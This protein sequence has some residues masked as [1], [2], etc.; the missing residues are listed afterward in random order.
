[1]T[2][3]TGFATSSRFER[4]LPRGRHDLAF[5]V[6]F[7]GDGAAARYFGVSR[8]SIWRWRRDRAPLPARVIKVLTDLI[9]AKVVEAHEAQTQ[10]SYFLREPPRPPRKLSGCC[11]GYGR[12]LKAIPRS[13]AEWAALG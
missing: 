3:R 8:T 7:G 12:R 11:A 2:P 6:A 1:M 4:R 5:K 13:H 9:Q 10:F